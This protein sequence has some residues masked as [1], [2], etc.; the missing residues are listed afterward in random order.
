MTTQLYHLQ[1]IRTAF[2]RV[3]YRVRLYDE[4]GN[5]ALRR[6]E[7]RDAGYRFMG[8]TICDGPMTFFGDDGR[9]VRAEAL[10][11]ARKHGAT[12]P[13]TPTPMLAA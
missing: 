7:V 1:R 9:K 6:V 5:L 3:G 4:G 12:V 13:F 8:Y 11:W 10:A 2:T